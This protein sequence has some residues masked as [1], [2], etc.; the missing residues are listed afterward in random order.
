MIDIFNDALKIEHPIVIHVKTKKGKG[1]TF[2]EENPSKY[3]GINS[4]HIETGLETVHKKTMTYTDVFSKKLVELA[5]KNKK[6]VAITAAMRDGQDLICL[7][8]NIQSC[9]F[10]VGIAEEHGCNLCGGTGSNQ[11]ISL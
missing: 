8:R 11:V 6:I 2:A 5:S 1:Y 10:D 3:H 7:Q 9:F 4:F